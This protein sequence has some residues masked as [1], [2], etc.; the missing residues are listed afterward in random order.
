MSNHKLF[1]A[2]SRPADSSLVETV[3]RSHTNQGGP[4]LSVASSR[5]ELV[6]TRHEGKLFCTLR[7]P[8]TH[9]TP[10]YCPPEGEWLGV[11]FRHGV[12]MPQLPTIELV[13]GQVEWPTAS[14]RSFWLHGSAWEFPTYENV[15]SFIAKL[16]REELLVEEPV[17]GAMLQNRTTDLT[18]RSMQRRFLRATGLTHGAVEQIVRAHYATHLLQQGAAILDAVELAGYYDQPHLTKALK[19]WIGL[20]P[21][22]LLA[23]EN[24]MP[25]SLSSNPDLAFAT[26][27]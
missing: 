13:K 19:R 11:Q 18:L 6:I 9:P 14:S 8:E 24:T 2:E 22:Q 17:V 21:A 5:L 3:W 26:L 20:T 15:E 7:G 12:F 10:A 1:H 25:L 16:V 23:Q 4:F 27:F